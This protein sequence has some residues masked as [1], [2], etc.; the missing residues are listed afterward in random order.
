MPGMV[1]KEVLDRIRNSL[2]IVE[3]IGSYIQVKRMGA[4]AKALCPF[5][6]EKTPSFTINA[7]RQAFYCFGCQ[8]GGDV[9]KFVMQYE[10]VDFPTA[11]R[12]LAARAGVALE[13]DEG[14]GTRREGPAKDEILSANEDASKCYQQELLRHPEA[15]EA[16]AY[17]EGRSL[18]PAVWKEWGIGYA[19][20]GWGFL[21][22]HA[23]GRS[24][25]KIKALEAAGLLS[26]NEKGSLYDRFRGRVMFTIRDELGRAVGFSG[27]LLRPE[28]SAA[29]KYI[30]TPET[31][32]FRKSRILFGLDKA[33]R[34]ILDQRRAILCEGQI[35]CIRCHLAG[36]THTVASQGTAFTEEHAHLL[37]RYADH[38]LVVLDADA[39]GKKAAL[40]TAELLLEEGLAVSLAALPAGEDPDTLIL[41]GGASAFEAVLENIQTP[42]E[43]LLD[44]LR[45]RMDLH[46]QEGLVRATQAV[47]DLASHAQGAAQSEHMLRTAAVA[48]NVRVSSLQQDLRSVLRRKQ[49]PAAYSSLSPAVPPPEIPAAAHPPPE[50]VELA[51]LLGTCGTPELAGFVRNWLPYRLLTNPSCRAVI[52]ALAEEEDL[53]AFLEEE[54]EDCRAFASRIVNS[55]KKVMR[56]TEAVEK[57]RQAAEELLLRIW[58]RHLKTRREELIRR[59]KA[60]KGKTH[61]EARRES[62]DLLLDQQK[63]KHGWA[64][65]QPIIE[66]HLHRLL[67]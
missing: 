40:R 51:M 62:T 18:G 36:F 65:A 24:G 66:R 20:E 2:D 43:F 10:N 5:H 21:T 16:R 46:R 59:M 44:L 52:H 33:K 38:I 37:K 45:S 60:M 11:V 32:V 63:L 34:A 13:F 1:S 53:M 54:S 29:G 31:L 19:P 50:E 67:D 39:A 41:K 47:L 26:K 25:N 15:A 9:F 4:S 17:L 61:E 55:P 7:T 30:N 56:E 48:L 42:M 6:K 64:S 8:V 28:K 27:R 12:M 58:R 57:V 22:D 49:R 35:D 23:G 14:G 3:V